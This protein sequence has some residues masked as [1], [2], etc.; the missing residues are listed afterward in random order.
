VGRKYICIIEVAT[1]K[2]IFYTVKK[3]KKIFEIKI[4]CVLKLFFVDNYMLVSDNKGF[5]IITLNNR[6]RRYLLKGD[7]V[8]SLYR[9]HKWVYIINVKHS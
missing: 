8:S 3:F 4:F 7:L 5:E 2:L 6:S 9:L 1:S